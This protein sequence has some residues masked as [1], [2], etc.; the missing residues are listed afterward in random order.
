MKNIV[1]TIGI[2]CSFLLCGCAAYQPY[3]KNQKAYTE[4]TPI[5]K[6][7]ID[8]ELYLVG[9]IGIN[10]KDASSDIVDILKSEMTDDG[11]KKSVVFLGN[12][13]NEDGFPETD[14]AK[15]SA[16]DKITKKCIKTF[17]NHTEKTFFIPGNK[18]WYDGHD[19]TVSAVQ[20]VE[21]YIQSKVNGKNIFVPSNGCGKP[22]APPCIL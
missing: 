22:S 4:P 6:S 3:V 10:S 15:F 21:D 18:E 2:L 1:Q 14:E 13:F 12:S 8:Y 7:K 5:P 17:K 16:I 20:D 19:Y 11:I 9:D